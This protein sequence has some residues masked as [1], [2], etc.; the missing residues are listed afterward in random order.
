MGSESNRSRRYREEFK[1]GAVAL[2]R[3]SGKTVTEVARETGVS[4][5]GLRNRV[6]QD[7]IDRGPG[8]LGELT[9][10]EREELRRVVRSDGSAGGYAGGPAAKHT[11]LALETAA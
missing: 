10:T 8:A 11:L 9:S 7:T 1:R 2:V 5:E 3:S 4:A 6:K